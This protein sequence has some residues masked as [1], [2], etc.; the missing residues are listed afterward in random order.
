MVGQAAR[1]HCDYWNQL[2]QRDSKSAYFDVVGMVYNIA[3]NH[4][5]DQG[6][7]GL[8]RGLAPLEGLRSLQLQLRGT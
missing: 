7:T 5:V 8:G 1:R 4:I 6:A 2:K 3:G